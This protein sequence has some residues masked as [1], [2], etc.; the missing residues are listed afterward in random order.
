MKVNQLN[1]AHAA[2]TNVAF[3]L[4]EDGWNNHRQMAAV[5]D[6]QAVLHMLADVEIRAAGLLA[7]EW[8][9]HQS[10]MEEILDLPDS[11]MV[12]AD[13]LTLDKQAVV[14]MLRVDTLAVLDSQLVILLQ[15]RVA[16]VHHSWTGLDLVRKVEQV[17][18]GQ[19]QSR[20]DNWD[21]WKHCLP[22]PH[23]E[24]R[25]S[26]NP[27][28]ATMLSSGLGEVTSDTLSRNSCSMTKLH[29]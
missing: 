3:Y 24:L 22:T 10:C 18:T 14:D 17:H 5:L 12:V 9:N 13:S 2:A 23:H 11:W 29:M 1:C 4:L 8:E 15:N 16:E 6:N 27:N 26:T 20:G 28:H 25:L 21:T 7:V 19:V